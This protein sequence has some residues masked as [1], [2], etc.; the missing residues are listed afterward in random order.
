MPGFTRT[1]CSIQIRTTEIVSITAVSNWGNVVLFT[2]L[3]LVAQ[4]VEQSEGRGFKSASESRSFFQFVEKR[5]IMFWKKVPYSLLVLGRSLARVN[6]ILYCR[7]GKVFSDIFAGLLRKQRAHA[8]KLTFCVPATASD[9]HEH[10]H[11]GT[12][13]SMICG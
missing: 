6:S 7:A 2:E 4:L 9:T 12:L 8:V 5:D 1:R 3:A 11:T 13:I 10:T